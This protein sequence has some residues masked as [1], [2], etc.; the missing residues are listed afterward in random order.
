MTNSIFNQAIVL[1]LGSLVVSSSQA[2][3]FS[4]N[5]QEMTNTGVWDN[6]ELLIVQCMS[7]E[8]EPVDF[9]LV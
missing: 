2:L 3:A 7:R 8:C 1:I 5:N 4:P 6:S 9:N